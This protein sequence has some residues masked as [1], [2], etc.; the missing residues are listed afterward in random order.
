MGTNLITGQTYKLMAE[1]KKEQPKPLTNEINIDDVYH[2]RLALFSQ[3]EAV[4]VGDIKQTPFTKITMQNLPQS[5]I[6]QL[7]DQM[8]LLRAM[9]EFKTEK[10]EPAVFPRVIQ[11]TLKELAAAFDHVLQNSASGSANRHME[12]AFK[13]LARL[14]HTR[15]GGN[16]AEAELFAKIF[17]D[18]HKKHGMDAFNIAMLQINP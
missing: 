17:L 14:F 6:H 4:F 7:N 11:H 10:A 3:G 1:Q 8:K 5:T 15:A 13:N 18:N 2:N 12:D 16:E 9:R